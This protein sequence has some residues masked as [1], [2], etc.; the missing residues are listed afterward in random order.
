MGK[1][2]D[3][4]ETVDSDQ[5]VPVFSLMCPGIS[6]S[7]LSHD[8][9]LLDFLKFKEI[10]NRVAVTIEYANYEFRQLYYTDVFV[11]FDKKLSQR[12]FSCENGYSRDCRYKTRKPFHPSITQT[13]DLVGDTDMISSFLEA[14]KIT[15]V[16][17]LN[18]ELNTD[19]RDDIAVRPFKC[20][21]YRTNQ[22]YQCVPAHKHLPHYIFTRYPRPKT[23][24]DM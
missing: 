15:D 4:I 3:K 16:T 20:T 6:L 23:G 21:E 17:W 9:R 11:S 5:M 18:Y 12:I 14:H 7:T 2:N 22:G 10:C 1:S 13:T 8:I 19:L 24:L